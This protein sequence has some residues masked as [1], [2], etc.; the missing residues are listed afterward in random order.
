[1]ARTGSQR[2]GLS[3]LVKFSMSNTVR[4]CKAANSSPFTVSIWLI[5]LDKD[6]IYS[7]RF[8]SSSS[9]KSSSLKYICSA[10][11][12]TE[13]NMC[14]TSCGPLYLRHT[15]A[16][17]PKALIASFACVGLVPLLNVSLKKPM[18][19]TNTLSPVSGVLSLRIDAI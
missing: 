1:M 19:Y 8:W 6:S 3:N 18:K 4:C 7:G 2:K 15:A 17:R 16:N 11:C 13:V 5:I 9:L 12:F 10:R 14:T